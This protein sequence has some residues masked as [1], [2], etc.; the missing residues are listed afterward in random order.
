MSRHNTLCAAFLLST[1]ALATRASAE[2]T[3]A[4]SP[5]PAATTNHTAFNATVR[6]GETVGDSQV[7]R[8]FLTIGT[9]EIAFTIPSGFFMDASNPQKIL[10]TDPDSNYFITVRVLGQAGIEAGAAQVDYFRGMAL[11]RF[12][13]AKIT[14]QSSQ[15]AANH[16]G[17]SFDLQWLT[18][19]GGAQSARIAFVPCAAGVLEFS[20]LTRTANFKAAQTYLTVLM[21]SVLSNETGKIV[22]IPQPG[23]S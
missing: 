5:A 21:T 15:F 1:L 2:E 19:N 17:P 11:N 23:Y 13:Q 9:N 20:I 12:P 10:L 16:S 6:G 18:A 4:A 8:T 3:P 14:S 7:H 22:I